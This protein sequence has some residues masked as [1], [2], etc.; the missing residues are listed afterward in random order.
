MAPAHQPMQGR[1]VD[2]RRNG[3]GVDVGD[4]RQPA[5]LRHPL[6]LQQHAAQEAVE[7]AHVQRLERR[8]QAVEQRL[9]LFQL[10]LSERLHRR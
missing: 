8:R 9:E 1:G 10:M 3:P 7:H 5:R 2:A 6:R 4:V